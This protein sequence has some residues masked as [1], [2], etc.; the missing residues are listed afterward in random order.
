[1]NVFA[2]KESLNSSG[3]AVGNKFRVIFDKL[4]AKDCNVKEIIIDPDDNPKLAKDKEEQKKEL[5]ETQE[6]TY[7]P[8]TI[9]KE[10]IIDLIRPRLELNLNERNLTQRSIEIMKEFL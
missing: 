8:I 3:V 2:G 1:M 7:I 6:V 5:L 10:N 9:T 4:K